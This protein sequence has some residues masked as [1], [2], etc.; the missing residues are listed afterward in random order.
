M[1]TEL[2]IRDL[3]LIERVELSFGEGLNVIT[4]E[5][6][7]GK[8]LL[9]GALEL[10]MGERPRPGLVR[11]GAARAEVEGRFQLAAGA[12]TEATVR[13]L[14]NHLPLVIED[15]EGLAADDPREVV[16]GRS[17]GR[18]GKTRGFVN[19]R[20]VTIKTLRGLALRLF[21]IHGQND[22]QKL[23]DASEQLILLDDFGGLDEPLREYRAARVEWFALVE[24]ALALREEQQSRRDRLDLARFQLAELDAAAVDPGEHERLTPEREVL[25]NAEGLK[26]GLS[27]LVEELFESDEALADRLRRAQRF[28]ELWKEKIPALG[29]VA[30]ELDAAC[31]HLE[32]AGLGLRS[33]TEGVEVDPARLEAVEGRLAELERLERKYA[34]GP[35]GL[36]ELAGEL[37]AEIAELEAL[38]HGLADIGP[39]LESVRAELL[40]AGGTLR[41]LRKAV[42]GK[43]VASVRKTLQGLGLER[44]EFDVRLG[45]RGDEGD[46]E[47][48]PDVTGLDRAAL[49]ADKLRFGERGMDRIEFLLSANPG[50]PLQ[51]LRQVAS[52]GETARIMLALRTVLARSKHGPGRERALVFDE[53]DSGVGGRLGPAVSEHL[54]KLGRYHQV[55]CVTH[56]P[57]IAAS[58][59]RHSRVH[60][61]VERGRTL[62][63][64]ETLSGERRVEEVADM[65]AGGGDQETARA[66]ARRLIGPG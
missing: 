48:A 36:V 49:E 57:A 1:L 27:N 12:S 5:T 30:D 18:D 9:V 17:V 29:T 34:R 31:L 13:W 4:G 24:R 62:T 11:E 59:A 22:H 60:K 42:R 6:G 45:Q 10:L 58:A 15:W 56:L 44:A 40:A 21:E 38:E 53:I 3:A 54:R 51:K 46:L 61:Q 28:V 19:Q 20:A 65:I 39:T 35:D 2:V 14:R 47:H 25:R 37:R 43:L 52:G 50:Q 7:A 26:G 23:L 63:R 64:V 16:L 8:S 33:F 41:R 66:E 55:L 32:E